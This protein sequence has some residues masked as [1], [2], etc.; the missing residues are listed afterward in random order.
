MD[1]IRNPFSPGAGSPPPELVGREGVLEDAAVLFAR[2]QHGRAEKSILLTGL[3]GVGKTVL[4]N[5]MRRS[6]E[7]VGY[8]TVFIEAHE[9]K[10]LA[11][12]LA[13]N[14]RSLLYELDR[15]EGAKEQIR[16][17]LA[18]LKSFI[19]SVKVTFDEVPVG[20]NLEPEKGTADSG[21]L[22]LDL[23]DLLEVVAQ[24]AQARG[25]SVALLIDEVQYFSE[26][27]LSALIMAMH[28]MQQRQLPLVLVGAGLPILPR[29]A[30][31]SKSYAERLF[32][33]PI[34]GAL[35]VEDTAKA[36]ELP[37]ISEGAAI[38]SSAVTAIADIT[39]GYPYFIQEWGYVVWNLAE[40][41]PITSE[42]VE[43]AKVYTLQRLDENF[44]RV[45]FDRLANNE[46]V[47]LRAMAGLGEGPYRMSDI[48]EAMG[49]KLKSLSPRRAKLLNKGMIYSP[50]YGE[51]AFTVPLFGDF[52]KRVM[53]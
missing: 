52:L 49:V 1:K 47:F 4:L 16:R 27:E 36:I 5:E 30:G 29:L 19:S 45:R 3:R 53:L 43:Q 11:E 7:G 25:R 10:T 51:L 9:D 33:F 17:G 13:P 2:V 32:Q 37:I 23:P 41:S 22:E 21:D 50:A 6:A 48:A 39:Q 34:I 44:F 8:H 46:K 42:V 18:V 12:L 40:A 26:K 14:L 31:N 35:S 38:E 28:R 20:L 24:A 15:I